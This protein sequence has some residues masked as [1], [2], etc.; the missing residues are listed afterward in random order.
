M[1]GDRLIFPENGKYYEWFFIYLIIDYKQELLMLKLRLKKG[2]RKKQPAYRIVLTKSGS[3]RNGRPIENLGF[4]NPC[5][6]KI[7]INVKRVQLRLA[8]GAQPTQTVQNI[9]L[10]YDY[11]IGPH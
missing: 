10:K 6:K 2:G 5:S 1:I 9:L 3:R 4:Y 11:H 8:Q 7:F